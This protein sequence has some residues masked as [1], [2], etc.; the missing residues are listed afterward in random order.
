MVIDDIYGYSIFVSETIVI[1]AS[2]CGNG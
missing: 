1:W 2:Q